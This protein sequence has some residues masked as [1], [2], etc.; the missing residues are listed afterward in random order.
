MPDELALLALD[1]VLGQVAVLTFAVRVVRLVQV[2]AL[3]GQL[4]L[5]LAMVAVVAHVLCVVLL[6]PVGTH[7]NIRGVSENQIHKGQSL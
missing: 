3:S 4:G 7:E 2:L 5:A 1:V 6:V